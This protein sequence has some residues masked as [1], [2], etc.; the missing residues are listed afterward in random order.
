M[1]SEVGRVGWQAAER[2]AMWSLPPGTIPGDL[3]VA[4]HVGFGAETPPGFTAAVSRRF[5]AA[6]LMWFAPVLTVSVRVVTAGLTQVGWGSASPRY[7]GDMSL[8]VL[9]GTTGVGVTRTSS[10]VPVRDG[11]AAVVLAGG[12]T[13]TPTPGGLA[14]GPALVRPNV[15]L[16]V[17]L[18]GRWG[19]GNAPAGGATMGGDVSPGWGVALEL[20]PPAGP[21]EPVLVS[22]DDGVEVAVE[23]AGLPVSWQHRPSR[24]GGSQAAVQVRRTVA[25]VHSWLSAAGAWVSSA[26][27]IP[28]SASSVVLPGLVVG[29]PTQWSV[30]T[31]EALDGT[32]SQYAP[33]RVVTRVA[34][35]TVAVSGPSGTVTDDLSPTVSWSSSTPRG[36]QTAWRVQIEQAGVQLWDSGVV[37]GPAQEMSV[38]ASV[39]WV[40]GLPH[41]AVVSVQQTGGSWSVP[42][43]TEFVVTWTLP[44]APLLS[45]S[46]DGAG[47]GIR[48]VAPGLQVEVQRSVD[49]GQWLPWVSWRAPG[50]M[51]DVFVASGVPVRYRARSASLLDGQQL[52]SGWVQAGPVVSEDHG[53]YIASALDPVATWQAVELAADATRQH[54]WDTS[55]DYGLGDARPRVSHGPHRGMSGSMTIRTDDAAG[56]AALEGLL[57]TG[58]PLLVRIPPDGSGDDYDLPEILTVAVSEAPGVERLAQ[59]L[60]IRGRLVSL[61]WVEQV[62]PTPG[63]SMAPVV[64]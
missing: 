12:Y 3:I 24:A 44:V 53:G 33:P 35:P 26:V 57:L 59:T 50:D 13:A 45:L 55:V 9:R 28:G 64:N 48:T 58:E 30:R 36:V 27:S 42:V 22:P 15:G 51:R 18:H 16:G 37:A 46:L 54:V 20:L 61:S 4:A 39:E 49:G 31:M 38:P 34:P 1:A 8:I 11:G 14:W 41:Q 60:L 29:Q 43:S 23:G 32:W 52:R 25:G 7:A 21:F 2:G 19:W 40:R 63:A 56:T 17:T 47:V 62:P 6:F 5:G 10:Q